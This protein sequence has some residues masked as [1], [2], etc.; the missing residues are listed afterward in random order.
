MAKQKTEVDLE[1]LEWAIQKA[2]DG[3]YNFEDCASRT[4]QDRILYP[5]DVVAAMTVSGGVYSEAAKLLGCTRS[6]LKG[7]I[8]TNINVYDVC[9]T[10]T[11]DAVDR[12]EKVLVNAALDGESWAVQFFLRSKAPDR[13]YSPK[14]NLNLGDAPSIKV[15]FVPAPSREE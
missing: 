12:V 10:L 8:D 1:S 9:R 2:D 11:E 14:S 5:E 6:R 15:E 4:N 7:Y 13:G 3:D